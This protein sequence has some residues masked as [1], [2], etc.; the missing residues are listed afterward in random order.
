MIDLGVYE[1][2][3]SLK[4]LVFLLNYVKTIFSSKST[5]TTFIPV[6]LYYT[7]ANITDNIYVCVVKSGFQF[8]MMV[9]N[10]S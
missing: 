7:R 6:G 8:S 1:S 3:K 2:I 9:L 10:V 4:K 5:Q